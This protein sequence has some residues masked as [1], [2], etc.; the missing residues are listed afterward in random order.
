MNYLVKRIEFRNE[1]VSGG[2]GLSFYLQRHTAGNA[3]WTTANRIIAGSGASFE[4]GAAVY[5]ASFTIINSSSGS[6]GLVASGDYVRL[7]FTTVGSAAN[8]SISMTIE[9]Q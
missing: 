8:V 7:F 5:Q 6:N 1:T 4:V 2:T 3:T 9:E